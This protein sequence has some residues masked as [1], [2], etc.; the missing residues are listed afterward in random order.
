MISDHF[1]S[2]LVCCELW[3]GTAP[4]YPLLKEVI[5]EALMLLSFVFKELK[6]LFWM[7]LTSL[8]VTQKPSEEKLP[9][10]STAALTGVQ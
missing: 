7:L 5:K 1:I 10:C 4:V 8:W 6:Q 2:G 3:D 9:D